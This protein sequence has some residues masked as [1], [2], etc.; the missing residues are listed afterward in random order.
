MIHT[1]EIAFRGAPWATLILYLKL[2][3][4]HL[5]NDTTLRKARWG[6]GRSNLER[7][8]HR[9]PR[10]GSN[11]TL[12]SWNSAEARSLTYFQELEIASGPP[13]SGGRQSSIVTLSEQTCCY[14]RHN[15]GCHNVIWQGISYMMGLWQTNSEIS[16]GASRSSRR[17]SIER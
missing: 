6:R 2:H 7:T 10:S 8:Y 11:S 1:I 12:V 15:P 14:H 9:V 5:R 4:G 13:E 17:R 16:S 3:Q